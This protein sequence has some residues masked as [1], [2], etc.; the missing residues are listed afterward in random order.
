MKNRMRSMQKI[1]VPVER[2][3][4]KDGPSSGFLELSLGDDDPESELDSPFRELSMP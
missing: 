4:V 3:K 1:H 2:V